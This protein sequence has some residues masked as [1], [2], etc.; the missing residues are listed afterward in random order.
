MSASD[1]LKYWVGFARA[2]GIGR[3]RLARLKEKFGSLCNAWNASR[4]DL[5]Q[6]GLDEKV[7]DGFIRVR[8]N[9][10]L[11]SEMEAL[12]RYHIK[13]LP[14]LSPEYPSLLK[15]IT[16]FP[17]VLFVRGELKPE[18]ETSIAVVGTRRATS[19]GR[20]V[21]DEIVTGLAIN[22]VTIVSG[23]AKGIDTAAHRAAM[24]AQGRTL[25]IFASGLDLVYPPENVKL[26]R[27]ILE[28]GA[29]ISEY[30][31]GTKPKAEHFPQRNRILSGL[32][33]GVLVV[34][35]GETSGA[36]ITADFALQ[37]DREV[38][39]VP[40]SIFSAMSKGPN[41]LIQEGAKLVRNHIDILEELNLSE[42]VNQYQMQ[43]V[44]AASETESIIIKC[45]SDGP[46]H[47][48]QICRAT[49]LTVATVQSNLAVMELNGIVK[50]IGNLNYA[51][52]KSLV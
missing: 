43:A 29:L 10:V 48:D 25:S 6:T 2:P 39:A 50:H 19:Y 37:Q 49:G 11:D 21:T 23:L 7:V 22:R 12:E 41:R 17:A 16:D 5:L 30:P 52:N 45:I 34:E 31:L 46:A 8:G 4:S 20:Q 32:S 44:N 9:I 14:Y 47:I 28:N 38:F 26:A 24:A 36:L 51:M 27:D 1:D 40:G 18:D 42:V 13:A 33:R 35:A 15:E 3:L